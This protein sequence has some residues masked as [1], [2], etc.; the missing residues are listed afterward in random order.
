MFFTYYLYGRKALRPYLLLKERVSKN[1]LTL[2]RIAL[3][4]AKR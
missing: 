1:V 4:A 2:V 3:D